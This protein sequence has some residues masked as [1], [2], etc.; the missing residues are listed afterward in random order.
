M[1]SNTCLWKNAPLDA[2]FAPWISRKYPNLRKAFWWYYLK[3]APAPLKSELK[4]ELAQRSL[5][6]CCH[7]VTSKTCWQTAVMLTCILMLQTD[8]AKSLVVSLVLAIS[9]SWMKTALPSFL[10]LLLN[11]SYCCEREGGFEITWMPNVE[12]R[13]HLEFG[14]T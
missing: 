12:Q 3:P 6:L 1:R 10:R 8:D 14:T 13:L 4:F 7:N 11:F 2:V 9:H 5:L